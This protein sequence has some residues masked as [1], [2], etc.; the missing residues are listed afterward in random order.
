MVPDATPCPALLTSH[1]MSKRF[2]LTSDG[3]T[4]CQFSEVL[5]L[6][7]ASSRAGSTD[8]ISDNKM[9]VWLLVLALQKPSWRILILG[10]QQ[11]KSTWAKIVSQVETCKVVHHG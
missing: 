6:V 7:H 1:N 5:L 4:S 8:A 2:W 11:E 3:T 9:L 10:H